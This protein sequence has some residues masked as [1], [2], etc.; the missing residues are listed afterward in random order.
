MVV[1]GM[2]KIIY[3]HTHSG[4]RWTDARFVAIVSRVNLS[5]RFVV[6]GFSRAGIERRRLLPTG[7]GIVSGGWKEDWL[8]D[9]R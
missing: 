1:N 8:I 6:V 5:I 2:V 4:M 9:S 7:S 3:L